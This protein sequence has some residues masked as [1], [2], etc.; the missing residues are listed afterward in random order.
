MICRVVLGKGHFNYLIGLRHMAVLF[1]ENRI[2]P[3]IGPGFYPLGLS[4]LPGILDDRTHP[5]STIV[6]GQVAHNPYTRVLHLDNCRNALGGANPQHWRLGLCWDREAIHR[7][8]F[9]GMTRQCKASDL[10]TAAI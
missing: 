1:S 9:K 2:V 5:V 3:K 10:R 6:V 4:F 7:D 8:H